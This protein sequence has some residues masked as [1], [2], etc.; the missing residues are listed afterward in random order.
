M[1]LPRLLHPVP[2]QIQ[3]ISTA[4]TEYD[5]DA[6]EPIQFAQR[7]TVKTVQGQ[8]QWGAAMSEQH[9]RGGAVESADGYVLLRYV[10]LQAQG[11]TLQR[12]DRFVKLGNETTDLYINRLVPVGH[13][14]D[15]GGAT[16]VK[17]FFD[18]RGPT[19]AAG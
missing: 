18:D 2:I 19:R 15:A 7:Q 6:R 13:Y 16:M 11:I 4:T 5:H 8:V 17:A 3:Q 9:T 14:P 1:P 10:D 12:E